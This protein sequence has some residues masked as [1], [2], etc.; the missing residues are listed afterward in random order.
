VRFYGDVTTYYRDGSVQV[1]TDA[2]TVDG[3]TWP[4]RELTYVWYSRGRVDRRAA[5][6]VTLRLG[7]IALLLVPF[8]IR[9]AAS[10]QIWSSDRNLL[11]KFGA[12][13]A[14]TVVS[15][16][17][18]ALL[19]PVI[20]IILSAVDRSYDRTLTVREIWVQYHGRDELVL[21]TSDAARFRRIYRA[22]ERAVDA[23]S[24][25]TR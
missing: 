9:L 16:S 23:T 4:I 1:T 20:E 22:I 6:R 13:V 5:S 10:A 7:L 19:V 15:L 25:A 11:H 3:R 2:V 17:V 24:D 18:L 21:R 14:L 12:A 8:A